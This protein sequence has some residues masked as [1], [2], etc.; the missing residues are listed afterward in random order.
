MVCFVYMNLGIWLK[1]KNIL[2]EFYISQIKLARNRLRFFPILNQ[3]F[4]NFS[5]YED[6]HYKE[7]RNFIFVQCRHKIEG[8][9]DL[10][11][12]DKS[13]EDKKPHYVRF[14]VNDG[15]YPNTLINLE[16]ALTEFVCKRN[17]K[18]PDQHEIKNKIIHYDY[19]TSHAVAS[20]LLIANHIAQNVGY[21]NVEY[22]PTISSGGKGDILVK[23]N[24]KKV[25]IEMTEARLTKPEEKIDNIFTKFA[26]ILSGRCSVTDFHM[27]LQ[28]NT[29]HLPLD[30][31]GHIDETKSV[32]ELSDW[33][34]KLL[35]HELAGLN[36][37]ID[38]QYIADV[39]SA[40]TSSN[41]RFGEFC[42]QLNMDT[43]EQSKLQMWANKIDIT[44]VLGSPFNFIG[45]SKSDLGMVEVQSLNIAIDSVNTVEE[46]SFL[47]HIRRKIQEK[48][49]LH[50]FED[51]NLVILFL[52]INS[53]LN[54]YEWDDNDFAKVKPI[55][56]KEI[57]I[58]NEISGVLLYY[59][60]YTDGR[61]VE[62]KNA[63]NKFSKKELTKIN[64]HSLA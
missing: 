30:T 38:F 57:E 6:L 55:I 46:N 56:E 4:S 49:R 31:N 45:L 44:D 50:Q 35:L 1:N 15:D 58:N 19:G 61:Y 34:D 25:Y 8:P 52:R 24:E 33:A 32:I 43:E 59:S 14:L 27:F 17:M 40:R 18:Q 20:E 37:K 29:L 64:I 48:I 21:D 47:N 22:G 5:G 3:W 26:K 13:S 12:F 51:N 42:Q 36:A 41:G 9:I 39:M 28:I 2:Q 16:E 63:K 7:S 11:M 53:W 60:D 10:S 62:N 54:R 23:I